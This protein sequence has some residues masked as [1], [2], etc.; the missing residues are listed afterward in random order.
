MWNPVVKFTKIDGTEYTAQDKT[1]SISIQQTL[2][3]ESNRYTF[4]CLGLNNIHTH[5]K[6]QVLLDYNVVLAG[7]VI[8]QKDALQGGRIKASTLEAVDYSWFLNYRIVNEVYSNKRIDEILVDILTKYVPE[9]GTDYIQQCN[10]TMADIRFQ[11]K[12][13][14]SAIQD[15]LALV[16]DWY[17]YIDANNKAHLFQTYEADG[18][19]LNI[20]NIRV[21]SLSVNYDKETTVNRVWIIGAKQAAAQYIDQYYTGDGQ[22]RYFNLSYEPNYTE[23]YVDGVKKNSKLVENDDSG[24]DFLIDKK[25][26]VI[27]IPDY[28]AMPY[29]G[30]IKVHYKPTIQFI[31]YFENAAES[32]V[33]LLEK[34]VKNKDVTDRLEARKYGKAEVKRLSNNKRKVNLLTSSDV[35]IGQRVYL[36]YNSVLGD[37]R[38]FYLITDLSYTIDSESVKNERI[39]KQLA[40]E[41]II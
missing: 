28:V 30:V 1:E 6:T 17:F 37:L 14:I 18:T 15:I 39:E 5:E 2:A 12:S 36:N 24:Q 32:S 20:N 41:E 9:I 7:W 26:K 27:Y 8:N 21:D 10:V 34:A 35:A 11:F 22:Q 23:I 33:I 3:L 40:L 31:D 29:T 19:E 38:G 4:N 13:A 25:A 16:P